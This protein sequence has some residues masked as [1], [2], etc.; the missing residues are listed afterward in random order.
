M[1]ILLSW[2]G[3]SSHDVALALRD[4]LPN[5][6]A[7]SRPWVSSEDIAKGSRWSDE[8]H[9]QLKK[10]NVCVVCVTPENVR[11][12]WLYYEAG[13][14]ASKLGEAAVCPYLVGVGHG[15]ITRTPLQLYQATEANKND[16]LKLLLSLNQRLESRHDNGMVEGNFQSVWPQ[17]KRRLD[18]VL[19]TLVPG[20]P[21]ISQQISHEAQGLLSAA[22]EG[23]GEIMF[24]RWLG[25][26]ELK[27]GT[28]QFLM[29][30]DPRSLALWKGALD[31]LVQFGLV[32]SVGSRDEIYRVTREGWNVYDT[33]APQVPVQS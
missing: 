3:K 19:D 23:N 33:L 29:A 10:S 25:G 31:E 6:L 28:R 8:L 21:P 5:A 1:D 15:D 17:L 2:S 30:D 4:W 26:R 11:S 13:V 12:P 14:V 16:T 18:K 22:C 32:Q 27:A 20:E 24:F 9:A 7:G